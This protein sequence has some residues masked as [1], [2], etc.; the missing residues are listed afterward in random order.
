MEPRNLFEDLVDYHVTR[1][2]EKCLPFIENGKILNPNI[3]QR[4]P[5][6]QGFG[7]N[8][9]YA[10]TLLVSDGNRLLTS[11]IRDNRVKQHSDH[12]S[13]FVQIEGTDG[14]AEYFDSLTMPGDDPSI[15]GAFIYDS[16]EG[17]IARV[18]EIG[19]MDHE[20]PID[21]AVRYIA[22]LFG[23]RQEQPGFADALPPDFCSYDQSVPVEGKSI[24]TKTRR[25]I[26]IPR[27][28]SN[29]RA[30]AYQIKQTAYTEFG[31]GKVTHF[32]KDGLNEEFF[33]MH[34]PSS[35][36]S[37]NPH[38]IIGVYRAYER[39]GENLTRKN[40][41][42]TPLPQLYERGGYALGVTQPDALIQRNAA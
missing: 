39:L 32:D 28:Y 34:E 41:I 26:D 9:L 30:Q 21:R 11:L 22:A 29:I 2:L 40:E 10:G 4:S 7:E 8:K 24:G 35:L 33:F 23:R 13:D 36:S 16:L 14:L 27:T 31:M 17:K 37:E 6:R 42:R 25:A 1:S 19:N 18:Y 38:S 12:L 3:S 15:E 20:K 5:F